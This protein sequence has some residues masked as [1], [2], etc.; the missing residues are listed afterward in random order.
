MVASKDLA[1]DEKLSEYVRH[2]E[3][4]YN[5]QCEDYKNKRMK[6]ETWKKI[7]ELLSKS[8]GTSSHD[9]ELLLNRYSRRRVAYRTVNVSGQSTEAI[10]K[11][12]GQLEEYNFL[13]WLNPFLRPKKSKTNVRGEANTS[14]EATTTPETTA[15]LDVSVQSNEEL[16]EI[17]V[18]P[19]RDKVVPPVMPMMKRKAKQREEIMDHV[20]KFL[21]YKMQKDSSKKSD[22]AEE[23]F[24]KMVAAELR[25][26]PPDRIPVAKHEISNIL[27]QHKVRPG[28]SGN[29]AAPVPATQAQSNEADPLEPTILQPPGTEIG[30]IMYNM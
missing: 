30:P 3:C 7:D 27:F 28:F 10:A 5:K 9:W 13:Q 17:P 23:I 6:D 14:T 24:G 26:L 12:K 20:S 15:D 16:Q 1:N 11:A 25:G 29:L 2:Y 8:A 19:V 22:D 4:L 21:K 18:T